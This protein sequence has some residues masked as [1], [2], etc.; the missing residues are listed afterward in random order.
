MNYLHKYICYLGS[1][2]DDDTGGVALVRTVTSGS[3][4]GLTVSSV[5]LRHQWNV[6]WSRGPAENVS[7]GWSARHGVARPCPGGR[8]G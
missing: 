7:E 4:P 1:T 5:P 8:A 3:L 6:V 2:N